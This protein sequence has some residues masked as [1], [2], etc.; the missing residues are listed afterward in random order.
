MALPG[1]IDTFLDSCWLKVLSMIVFDAEAKVLDTKI[2]PQH[3]FSDLDCSCFGTV[4]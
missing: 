2:F 3:T 4:L 1:L